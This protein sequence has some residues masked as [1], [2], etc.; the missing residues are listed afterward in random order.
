M[1]IKELCGEVS[2]KDCIQIGDVVK[3]THISGCEHTGR[4]NKASKEEIEV[5]MSTIKVE[6]IIKIETHKN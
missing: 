6:E 1:G 2:E 4:L 3:V 5:G